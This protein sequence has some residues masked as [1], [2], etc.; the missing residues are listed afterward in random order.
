[1]VWT[2]LR[3]LLLRLA[4]SA[5][6]VSDAGLMIAGQYLGFESKYWAYLRCFFTSGCVLVCGCLR[7]TGSPGFW[8]SRFLWGRI[9]TGVFLLGGSM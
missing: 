2:L 9:A 1:M 3:R 7:F 8:R 5:M 6:L 4:W